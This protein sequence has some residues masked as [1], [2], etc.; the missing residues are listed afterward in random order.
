MK[1]CLNKKV[2]FVVHKNVYY[3]TKIVTLL[4]LKMITLALVYC[5]HFGDPLDGHLR[6]RS[7]ALGKKLNP[8]D[9]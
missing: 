2:K 8:H 1:K 3:N 9:L 5:S 6:F 7:E 4:P